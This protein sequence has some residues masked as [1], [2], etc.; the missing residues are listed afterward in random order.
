MH[1][2][3]KTNV[4]EQVFCIPYENPPSDTE[5]HTEIQNNFKKGS[6]FDTK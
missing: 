4:K 1:T 2:N 3:L 5:I 6:P